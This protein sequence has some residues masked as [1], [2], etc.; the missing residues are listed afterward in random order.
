M[1]SIGDG[2]ASSTCCCFFDLTGSRGRDCRSGPQ[3]PAS[4]VRP[5]QAG[6]SALYRHLSVGPCASSQALAHE[7]PVQMS[8][9]SLVK[10]GS[11]T[12]PKAPV[13]SRPDYSNNAR[14]MEFVL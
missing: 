13:L 10:G 5:L 6:S 12:G 11:A 2:G 4:I 9:A 1:V 7:I 8:C 14:I 3:R